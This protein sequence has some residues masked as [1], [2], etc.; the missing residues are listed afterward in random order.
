MN[1]QDIQRRDDG[2][3]LP[4]TSWLYP[5]YYDALNAL[6]RIEN[7][8]RVFVYAIL[9]NV[10][11]DKWVEL[12]IDSDDSEK[13]TIASIAKK[14]MS[15]AGNFGYLGYPITCPI[16]HLTSGELI[17]I[18]TSES[19]WKHFAKYFPG[20]KEIIRNKLDEIGTIRNSLAHFRPLK[21]EDVALI[22]QNA[23]HVL[24]KIEQELANLMD[25][26]DDIPSNTADSSCKI[27]RTLGGEVCKV[28]LK[29]SKNKH[30]NQLSL[31]VDCPI[32]SFQQ[33]GEGRVNYKVLY[34]SPPLM[35]YKFPVMRRFA[36]FVTENVHYA[37][38]PQD[39][40][41]HFQK[42]VSFIFNH[43][44]LEEKAEFVKTEVES[45][46]EQFASDVSLVKSDVLA[47]GEILRS[48]NISAT[49]KQVNN[50]KM[51]HID[52]RTMNCTIGDEDPPEYWGDFTIFTVGD[53]I[54]EIDTYPWM[55]AS[56]SPGLF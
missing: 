13:T 25:P 50:K 39:L 15:Q 14:R 11:F 48:A 44:I 47:Q 12:S 6:F 46:F 51:W 52:L 42:S 18:I 3:V 45:I 53:V 30:W 37:E 17:R 9:K 54:T 23:R 40:R 16:L 22:K 34:P 33:W 38:M 20:S 2:S 26:D 5:H 49:S 10:F 56:V 7:G 8:L 21:P 28:V 19:Y 32:T 35:L 24:S 31:V 4:P 43:A 29:Q 55:K 27:L 1:W 36:T 41:P